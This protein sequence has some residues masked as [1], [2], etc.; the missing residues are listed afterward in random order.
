MIR[1]NGEKAYKGDQVFHRAC[2]M[3]STYGLTAQ[4]PAAAYHEP[5][6]TQ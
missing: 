6:E 2:Y 4:E 1:V 3:R 5:R